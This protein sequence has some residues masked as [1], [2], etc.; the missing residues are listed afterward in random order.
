MKKFVQWALT[1]CISVLFLIP[2]TGQNEAIKSINENDLKAHLN[3][4]ASDLLQGRELGTPVPGLEI[5]ASY[6]RAAAAR[7]GLKSPVNDFFQSVS[8]VSVSRDPENSYLQITDPQGKTLV[9]SDSVFTFF[10]GSDDLELE[11]KLVF[12]GYGWQDSV[13]GYDDL[14]GLDVKDKLVMVMTRNPEMAQ[15]GESASGTG[16]RGGFMTESGKIRRITLAGAKAV[17]LV[18]D[19]L[20]ITGGM[21]PRI[22]EMGS[23]ASYSLEG[24]Q[25]ESRGSR[26]PGNMFFITPGLANAIM[27]VSGKTLAGLQNQIN[28]SGKPASF[29][30][31]GATA[32]INLVKIRK[33]VPAENIVGMVEGSDPVL[34]NECVIYVAHYDHLGIDR[35]GNVYNGADDNASG[36]AGLLEIAEAFTK[37]EKKPKRSVV[38]AWVTGEE[39][40]LLGSQYYSLHP[41]IPLDKT[42]ACIDLDMIGRV[43]ADNDTA[44]F[45]KGEK[46]LVARDGVYVISGGR[47]AELDSLNSKICAKMGLKPDGSMSQDYINRSDYAH[48]H[49]R[50]IPILGFSTGVHVDYH[51]ITDEI[52]KLDFPKMKVV[53]ELA[54][55]V[56]YA[57]ADKKER[58][59]V[60]KPVENR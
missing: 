40:G 15:K 52:D 37:L 42:V 56:G 12:A 6:I 8:M 58:I 53:T 32:K 2:A 60:D 41:V 7:I 47:S 17:I 51:T 34:K 18:T 43:K 48:F 14:G 11:G 10:G 46:N 23:R 31:P 9:K 35:Q 45:V 29:E 5:A 38:F 25:Q 55:R 28:S 16:R 30:L 21:L 44:K 20:D 39:I 3:F 24:P 19:P 1:G 59:I 36:V 13:K 27:A 26:R 54:F 33:P 57:V 49:R 4:L 22:L 50:G